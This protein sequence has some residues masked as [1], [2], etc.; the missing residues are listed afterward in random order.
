ME[1]DL[2]TVS[3]INIL[4]KCAD[5]NNLLVP[6]KT[7]TDICV[8]FAN[9]VQWAADNAMII[10]YVDKTKEIVFHRPLARSSLP[11]AIT[12]IEQVLSVKLLGVT[13]SN[14]LRFDEHVKNILTICNQRCHLLKCL[15]GQGLP[16]EQLNIVFLCHNSLAY[17]V[18]PT[19]MGRVSYGVVVGASKI[20]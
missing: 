5:D 12:G 16:S 19:C 14:T 11:S 2:K 8:E 20:I 10:N 3:K 17:L 7:D 4:F 18:C 15:K 9:I 13:F 6:E 1:S